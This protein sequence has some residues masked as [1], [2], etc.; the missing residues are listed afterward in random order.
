MTLDI[1]RSPSGPSYF[2]HIITGSRHLYHSLIGSVWSYG[3]IMTVRHHNE[4][5][6]VMTFVEIIDVHS[7][8]MGY[9]TLSPGGHHISNISSP[10][11]DTHTIVAHGAPDEMSAHQ[12]HITIIIHHQWWHSSKL[13]MFRDQI[14]DITQSPL[15]PLYFQH[16]FQSEYW[17]RYQTRASISLRPSRRDLYC[18]KKINSDKLLIKTQV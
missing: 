18:I 3:H 10:D 11:S 9:F 12:H 7:Y 16:L 17:W 6:S 2:K 1:S 5:S 8:H 13:M 15:G 4:T 14:M